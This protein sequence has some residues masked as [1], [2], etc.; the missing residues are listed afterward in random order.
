MRDDLRVG[1]HLLRETYDTVR[2]NSLDDFEYFS[3]SK[4]V[5]GSMDA[6]NNRIYSDKNLSRGSVFSVVTANFN[7]QNMTAAY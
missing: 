6:R 2:V 4:M 5:N 1:G 7:K 3:T